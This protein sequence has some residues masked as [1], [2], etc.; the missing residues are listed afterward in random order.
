L[1]SRLTRMLKNALPSERVTKS[2]KVSGKWVLTR[3][4]RSTRH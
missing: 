1:T 4:V 2:L 3:Y